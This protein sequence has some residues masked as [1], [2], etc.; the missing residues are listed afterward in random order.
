MNAVI[1]HNRKTSKM[2]IN[3][4]RTFTNDTMYAQFNIMHNWYDFAYTLIIVSIIHNLIHH[5]SI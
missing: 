1:T 2:P 5:S 4:I 3:D